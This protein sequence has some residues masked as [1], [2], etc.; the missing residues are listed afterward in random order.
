MIALT[1]DDGPSG[2][3]PIVLNA[4][5]KYKV[6]VTFFVVGSWVSRYPDSVKRAAA[7]GCEIG[8]HTYAHDTLT[9]LNN[10]QIKSVLSTTNRL[11]KKYAGV[12]IHIMRPPGGYCNNSVMSA[13]GMPVI[14]WSIDPSDWRTRNTFATIQYVEQGAYDGAIVLMHDLHLS[15]ANAA[16]TIIKDLKAKGY[17]LVTVS[18]LAAYRGGMEAGRSYNQFRKYNMNRVHGPVYRDIYSRNIPVI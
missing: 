4:V 15:T 13:V 5:E 18:E 17:Q 12:D 3:T 11:V 14:M 10:E 16:D 8:N 6:H 1:Y 9:R 7:L 2:H